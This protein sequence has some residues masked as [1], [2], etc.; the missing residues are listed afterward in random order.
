MFGQPNVIY[1]NLVRFD[2]E[3]GPKSLLI[4]VSSFA[5]ETEPTSGLFTLNMLLTLNSSSLVIA[6][7]YSKLR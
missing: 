3:G 7:L 6:G 2:T 5:I 1:N 4:P